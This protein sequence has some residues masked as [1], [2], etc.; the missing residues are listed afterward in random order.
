MYC[1]NENPQDFL[2]PPITVW[3][4]HQIRLGVTLLHTFWEKVDS[5]A[6]AFSE[7]VDYFTRSPEVQHRSR[8]VNG[9]VPWK[10]LKDMFENYIFRDIII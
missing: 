3:C 8:G 10:I 4:H 9:H 5:F 1:Y 6:Y 7:I 2:P